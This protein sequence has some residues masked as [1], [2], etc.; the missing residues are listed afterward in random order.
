MTLGEAVQLVIE[1][2]NLSKGGEIFVLDMGKLVKI[3]E[4]AENLINLSGKTI[5]NSENPMGDIEIKITGLLPGEKLYEEVLIDDNAVK[6]S[7]PKI[8]KATER[9]MR[10][11]ERYTRP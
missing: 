6:T 1:T 5:K 2:S 8:L 7:N 9:T 11:D 3:K 4:L 10:K